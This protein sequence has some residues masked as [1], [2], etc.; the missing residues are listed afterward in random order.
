MEFERIDGILRQPRGP[1]IKVADSD[2]YVSAV[3][4]R[5]FARERD[6][7][8]AIIGTAV[9]SLLLIGAVGFYHHA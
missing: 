1:S 5:N 7:N 8:M 3:F 6:V 2:G 9:V 4:Q